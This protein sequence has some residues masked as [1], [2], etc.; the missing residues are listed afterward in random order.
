MLFVLQVALF[1]LALQVEPD[2]ALQLPGRNEPENTE[3][4]HGSLSFKEFKQAF[5]GNDSRL[6]TVPPLVGSNSDFYDEQAIAAK[7]AVEKALFEKAAAAKKAAAAAVA[8]A[9]EKAAAAKA[10]AELAAAAKELAG[11]KAAPAQA[12]VRQPTAAPKPAPR[13]APLPRAQAPVRQPT[14]APKPALA[15]TAPLPE[16]TYEFDMIVPAGVGADRKINFDVDGVT[17]SMILPEGV[18]EGD[19]FRAS[20]TVWE[21]EQAEKAKRAAEAE[22]AA[23][24]AAVKNAAAD[25]A[26]ADKAAAK[27]AAAKAAA[28]KAAAEKAAAEA[29]AAEAAAAEAA[30]AEKEAVRLAAA[31][32]AQVLVMISDHGSGTTN[33]GAAL[34][35]HPCVMDLGEP[36]GPS[37][38]LW[39]K[40]KVTKEC[41]DEL[42][43][44][45]MFD[46][47]TGKLEHAEN[48]K[49]KEKI[50]D[51]LFREDFTDGSKKPNIDTSKLYK[52]LKYNLA[53]YFVRV[54]DLVCENVPESVCPRE[55]CTVL[56]KMFPNY[57]YGDT[58]TPPADC[59]ARCQCMKEQNK[60]ALR[61]W[62]DMLTAFEQEPKISTF[63]FNRN[64][65]AR[66]FSIFHRFSPTGEEFDCSIPHLPTPYALAAADHTDAQLQAE[67]CWKD[68]AKCLSD[69]LE[70]VGL[71]TEKM[72]DET[73]DEMM[74]EMLAGPQQTHLD[75]DSRSCSTDPKATFKRL[76]NDQVDLVRKGPKDDKDDKDALTAAAAAAIE[77]ATENV[78]MAAVELEDAPQAARPEDRDAPAHTV[79]E[80]G[81]PSPTKATRF[82]IAAPAPTKAAIRAP[83][84]T[85][86]SRAQ[87]LVI[88]SDHGSGTTDFG[89]ALNTH[90]CILDLMEP[91][92]DQYVLWSSSKVAECAARDRTR[93]PTRSIFD[94][95]TGVLTTANNYKLNMTIERVLNKFAEPPAWAKDISPTYIPSGP[96]DY[97]SLYTGLPYNIAEYFVRIRNLVCKEVPADV[98]PPSDCTISL[99]MFPQ[100]VNAITAGQ[101]TKEDVLS[102][103]ESAQNEHAM[104]SWKAALA[105][106][107]ANPKVATLH[108]SRIEVDR[109]FS[110][111]HRFAPAGSEF[112]CSIPRPSH[113]F[114]AV[115]HLNTDLQLQSEDCW[116]GIQGANRCLGDALNLVGL[117]LEPMNGKGAEKMSGELEKRIASEKLAS[118]SCSTDPLGTFMRMANNDVTLKSIAGSTPAPGSDRHPQRDEPLVQLDGPLAHLDGA[119]QELDGTQ[120]D[121]PQGGEPVPGRVPPPGEPIPLSIRDA[122]YPVPVVVA[123]LP[124]PN[125]PQPFQLHA[126]HELHGAP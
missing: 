19:T 93:K 4:L 73:M 28:E 50:D 7:E 103:C 112:D 8:R 84:P 96:I 90:P 94:A 115:S 97:D 124:Q 81:V 79:R 6:A 44:D 46:A 53:D 36:F 83:A 69:A 110:D 21:K 43:H 55:E 31:K 24:R 20:I 111:F 30:A 17:Y 120:L 72:T 1:G 86:A 38:M 48:P 118:K 32:A 113:E 125:G 5:I 39:A 52:G 106:L 114:A 3:A 70:L 57:V 99:K 98:C 109:Q 16:P 10:A 2:A 92:G 9:A 105:S 104:V 60:N 71:T 15:N 88:I 47:D 80:D 101:S 74:A 108:Y 76:A 25:K 91:F 82:T 18:A 126:R 100:Y 45:A 78:V 87:V 26:A 41:Q 11:I 102:E 107:K 68:P 89:V 64:E 59:G 14:A 54:R 122:P 35:A 61:A 42:S 116:K 29:A 13:T 12:P 66:L 121:G 51:A 58:A 40:S 123:R 77:I 117:T 95:D 85:Q 119:P 56:L 33:L 27:A 75:A 67:D 63:Q 49:M 22:A 65:Q 62:N 37:F 23:E 34:K